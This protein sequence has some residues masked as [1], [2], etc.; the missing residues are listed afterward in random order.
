MLKI[1]TVLVVVLGI[2]SS[3]C[4]AA[5]NRTTLWVFADEQISSSNKDYQACGRLA[6]AAATDVSLVTTTYFTIKAQDVGIFATVGAN[7]GNN[8]NEFKL[9]EVIIIC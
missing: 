8:I 4:W 3:A 5:T 9:F 2:C 6:S 1:I 7:Q